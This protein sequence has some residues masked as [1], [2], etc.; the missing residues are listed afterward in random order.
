MIAGDLQQIREVYAGSSYLSQ[1]SMVA[2][3]GLGHRTRADVVEI[4]WADGTVQTLTDIAADQVLV[5]TPPGAGLVSVEPAGLQLT[6][7]G[8]I[9]RF[10]LHPNY[11]NPF[12]PETWMPF[13]LGEDAAVKI[14]IYDVR[15]NRIRT[16]ALGHRH[17][18]AYLKKS[19]AAYWD[20]KSEG[21]EAVAS[22]VY[23]YKLTATPTLGGEKWTAIKNM[24]LVK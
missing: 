24:V 23:F 6:T 7:W 20:G 9:R 17:A 5:L 18:G 8:Q 14:D 21:G 13:Q 12:N 11:P 16:L 19:Q 22:G 15:G 4:R 2:A 3:F 10:A 1:E